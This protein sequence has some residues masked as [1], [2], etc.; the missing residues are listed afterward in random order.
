MKNI[1]N[2]KTRTYIKPQY[3]QD[4]IMQNNDVSLKKKKKRTP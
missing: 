1:Y 4:R 2:I 3:K